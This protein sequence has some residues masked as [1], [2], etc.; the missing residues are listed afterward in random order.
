MGYGID[1]ILNLSKTE[2]IRFKPDRSRRPVRFE[3]STTTYGIT[4]WNGEN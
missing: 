4:T 1:S 3:F 2:S